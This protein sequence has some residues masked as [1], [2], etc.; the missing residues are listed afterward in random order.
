MRDFCA[1]FPLSLYLKL[2]YSLHKQFQTWSKTKLKAPEI[3][4][5]A[6]LKVWRC[7]KIQ[8][9]LSNGLITSEQSFKLYF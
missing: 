7:A 6:M 2:V 1:I 8:R 3:F 5:L 4:H 9:L